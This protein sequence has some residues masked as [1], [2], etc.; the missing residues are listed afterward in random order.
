[1]RKSLLLT[2]ILLFLL[3]FFAVNEVMAFNIYRVG[4]EITGQEFNDVWKKW[5]NRKFSIWVGV[6]ENNTEYIFFKGTTGIGDATVIVQNSKEVVEKLKSVVEKAIE[7]ADIARK[8]KA[9]TSKSL[10]CFNN[11]GYGSCRRNSSGFNGNQMDLSFFAANSGK[12][13]SLVI[14]LV[15]KDNQFIKTSIYVDLIEMKK[16]LKVISEIENEFKKAQ[17]TAKDQNLFK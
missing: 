6:D 4:K 11:N 14:N 1:M 16:L 12:Q 13:T 10:E 2:T 9:D 5:F 15:D 8:N 17:K 7:W 3:F